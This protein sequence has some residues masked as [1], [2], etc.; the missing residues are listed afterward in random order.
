MDRELQ[1]A[2]RSNQ[3]RRE[4][5]SVAWRRFSVDGSRCPYCPHDG[6]KHLCSSGQPHIFRRATAEERRNP[7]EQL[8]QY[9]S[10]EHGSLLAKR[11]TVGR[12]AEIIT[13]FCGACA[14]ELGTRQVLCFQRTRAT[15]EL[16]GE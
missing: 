9:E 15:G 3:R 8:Y 12:D 1:R 2:K 11:I 4:R 10:A 6:T 13:A 16:V 14:E 5:N 7:S